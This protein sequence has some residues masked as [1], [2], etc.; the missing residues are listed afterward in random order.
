MS[1][2]KLD[3]SRAKPKKILFAAGG[4]GGH[5]FPAQA[6]AELIQRQNHRLHLLFAGAGLSQ[7]AYFDRSKFSFR[8]IQSSS[9]FCGKWL[10]R[11][12]SIGGLLKGVLQSIKLL[13]QESPD[14]IIGFGSHHAFPILCAAVFKRIPLVLFES[15]AIP[16]KVIRLFSKSALF[17]AIHFPETVRYLK[18]KTVAVDIPSLKLRNTTSPREARRHFQLDSERFTLLVFGGSQ[19]AKGINQHLIEL[20]PRLVR[21]GVDFQLIHLTGNDETTAETQALCR[22]YSIPSY[23]RKFETQMDLA[24]SAADLALCRA[25]AATLSELIYFETPGLLIPYPYAADQHQ[26]KNAQFVAKTIGGVRVFYEKS[27][28]LEE[29]EKAIS[30]CALPQSV[31]REAM[32]KSLHDLKLK[33]VKSDLVALILDHLGGG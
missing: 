5:L 9:F 11:F 8:E 7:S 10:Q 20:I 15:N 4:T 21:K 6:L 18:G 31:E 12:R 33:Q 30:D 3:I 19:G 17:T 27:F 24:W 16:G 14:L 32:K 23:I 28:A 26:L 22:Q 13:T 1:F 29:L 2:P 25:G